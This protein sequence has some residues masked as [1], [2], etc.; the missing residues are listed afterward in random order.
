M[1]A[2]AIF[3]MGIGLIGDQ[4][5]ANADASGRKEMAAN[6]AR[7][8]ERDRAYLEDQLSRAKSQNEQIRIFYQSIGMQKQFEAKQKADK[9][10]KTGIVILG[11][12]V[13]ILAAIILIRRSNG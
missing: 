1:S 10:R 12:G 13:C 11:V 7:L 9:N 4:I 5:V 3:S 8:T 6:L 2:G